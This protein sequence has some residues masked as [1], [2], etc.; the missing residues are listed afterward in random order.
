MLIAWGTPWSAHSVGP[1]A[2]LDVAVLDV[3]VD[4]AEVVAELDGRG[5]RAGPGVLA[6]DRGVGE[7]A[8]EGAH[9]LAARHVRRRPGP[10]GSGS[11]RTRR[12]WTASWPST[13]AEDLGLRVLE[14]AAEV[15]VVRDR[16][17][18]PSVA[19][20]PQ[21]CSSKVACCDGARVAI[22]SRHGDRPDGIRRVGVGQH[23]QQLPRRGGSARSRSSTPACPG[24]GAAWRP[25]SRRWAAPSTT[26][27]RSSLTHGHSDHIGFAERARRERG[28]PVSVHELDA[29]L[30]VAR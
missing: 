30:R 7:E 1:V 13:H 15:D 16:H 21:T 24:S 6:R 2:P 11:S 5:A 20:S 3:V 25:S 10:G 8:E 9:P 27:A 29:A 23:R 18:P 14:E 12:P 28:W 17:A 22:A 19:A 26:S 4:E